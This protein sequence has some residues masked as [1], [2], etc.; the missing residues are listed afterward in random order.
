M[1]NERWRQVEA[2]FHAAL[3]RE[4]N[5][6]SAFLARECAG[7]ESM[8]LEVESLLAS[9]DE[10]EYGLDGTDLAADFLGKGQFQSAVGRAFGPYTVL[11]PLAT[12]GM[13]AVFIAQDTKLGRQVALKLLPSDLARD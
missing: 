2:L 6:R 10:S 13:G 4:P 3:E 11:R 8:R 7:D 1:T 12:G 9:H 5:E